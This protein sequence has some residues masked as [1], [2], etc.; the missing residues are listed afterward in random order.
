MD[1]PDVEEGEDTEDE[2]APLV[3]ALYE[4]TDETGDDHELA[5]E[6]RDEDVREGEAGAEEDREQEEGEG[7]EPLDVADILF[8]GDHQRPIQ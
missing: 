6:E 3:G 7:E 5:H 1:V 8:D 2:E 4:C